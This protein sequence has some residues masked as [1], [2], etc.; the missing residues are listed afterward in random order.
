[1]AS[2]N[3]KLLLE[4]RYYLEA[5]Y[6]CT[7]RRPRAIPNFLIN[8]LWTSPMLL[9]MCCLFKF[10]V[11]SNFDLDVVSSAFALSMGITQFILCFMTLAAYRHETYEILEQLQCLVDKRKIIIFQYHLKIRSRRE[12]TLKI[13]YCL[14]Q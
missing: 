14:F 6:L 9:D 12:F 11:D 10:C 8:I 7:D 1:M 2:H 5:T 3:I 4:S 13:L